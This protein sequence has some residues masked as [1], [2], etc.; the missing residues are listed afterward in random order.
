MTFICGYADVSHGRIH[1]RESGTGAPL[2]LLHPAT[3]SSRVFVPLLERLE[4]F[5]AIGVDLPGF[6]A[7]CGLPDRSTMENIAGSLVEFLTAMDIPSAHAFGVH[8][9]NKVAASLAANWPERVDHLIIAGLRHSIIPDAARR[10][11]A[12]ASYVASKPSPQRGDASRTCDEERMDTPA[13]SA[14]YENLYRANYAFDLAQALAGTHAPTLVL[15]LAITEEECLGS[16]GQ[17]LAELMPNARVKR[18]HCNDREL[19]EQRPQDLAQI[20]IGFCINGN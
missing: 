6:G 12:M 13:R 18:L 8:S 5:R 11:Q 9:G 20:L 3:R 19:L 15:E 1:Y 16:P 4:G 10:N 14:A 17:A 7:S 2:I